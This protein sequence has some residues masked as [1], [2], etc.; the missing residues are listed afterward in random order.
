MVSEVNMEV[1]WLSLDGKPSRV[2]WKEEDVPSQRSNGG[3]KDA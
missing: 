3:N 1:K 2:P